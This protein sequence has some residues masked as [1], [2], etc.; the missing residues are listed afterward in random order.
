MKNK[1]IIIRLE[2][3]DKVDFRVAML[4]QR[5]SMQNLLQSF[6]DSFIS[7]DKGAKNPYMEKIV[8]KAAKGKQ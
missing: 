8:E 4:R 5:V 7:F 2:E 6:I 1:S 3:N